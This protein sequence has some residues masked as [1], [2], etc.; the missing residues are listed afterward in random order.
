MK[1]KMITQIQRRILELISNYP[2]KF[3]TL[4]LTSRAN[5][6]YSHG[7]SLVRNFVN[8]GAIKKERVN[9]REFRLSL[10]EKGR[11]LLRC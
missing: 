2:D 9:G 1:D 11:E 10:T 8:E 5:I 7:L 6:T 3:S 4:K